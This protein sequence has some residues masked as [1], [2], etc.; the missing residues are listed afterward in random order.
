MKWYFALNEAGALG[1]LGLYA[2][3]ALLSARQVGG[4]EPRLLYH[5][6][7]NGFTEWMEARDV[8]V[9]DAAPR[10]LAALQ[11]TAGEQP[12]PLL[13]HWL[14]VGICLLEA[15]DPFVLYTDCDVVFRR[16]IN[17]TPC[18]PEYFACGPERTP[19]DWSFVNTGVMV[20][21]VAGLRSDYPA[22]EAFIEATLAGAGG[23]ELNDQHVYNVFYN[24]RWSRLHPLLNWKP[25]WGFHRDAPIV[26]FHGP[27]LGHMRM[28]LDGRVDWNVKILRLYASLFLANLP[29]YAATLEETLPLLDGEPEARGLVEGIVRD[30]RALH[31]VVPYDVI[32]ASLAARAAGRD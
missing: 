9:I 8:P 21:N 18:Q 10:F 6:A 26:H 27:K 2:K 1:D 20:Q 17:F 31:G 19:E 30:A 14:R 25:Y 4:L 5:G 3:L 22:F 24:G 23:A 7:R 32:A 15:D 16:R 12:S 13:G 11:A 29:H 28:A